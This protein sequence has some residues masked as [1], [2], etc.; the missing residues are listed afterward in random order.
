MAALA[1]NSAT[2]IKKFA[3]CAR[4]WAWEYL[5]GLKPPQGAAA[6]L[7][8]DCH[9]VLERWLAK[10]VSPDLSSR[11]G[12]IV[13][14]GLAHLP[15]PGPHLEVERE[16]VFKLRGHLYRGFVDLGYWNVQ[17]LWVVHDHKTTS[18]FMWALSEEELPHDVQAILYAKEALDRH[19]QDTVLLS[20]LYMRT[21]GK[22]KAEPRYIEVRR[23]EI[24]SGML[25]IE[26]YVEQ[27]Q[28]LRRKHLPIAREHPHQLG[29]KS[30]V[31][32]LEP[33]AHACAAFG[34]CPFIERCNL[35]KR[36]KIRSI[37]A[38]DGK[39]L[40]LKERMANRKASRGDDEPEASKPVAVARSRKPEVNP[41]EGDDEASASLEPAKVEAQERA[42][43]RKPRVVKPVAVAEP[44][45]EEATAEPTAEETRGRGRPKGST[46]KKLE[47]A[48]QAS[49]ETAF[50]RI[51][52]AAVSG[53]EARHLNI[54][55]KVWESYKNEFME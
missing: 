1:K 55:E 15:T 2:Q 3:S 9:A 35:T 18:D 33:N 30:I 34:G 12:N 16:F 4:L 39:K 21:R 29:E 36:E 28:E 25:V 10:G 26:H 50:V 47:E 43:G 51:F 41:P 20:W 27:M 11:E 32:D 40:S 23:D 5:E 14:P 49:H 8:Q 24:E 46:N 7:G 48:S 53:G 52:A 6:T 42:K 17:G 31:L 44:A 19:E 45:A 22:P 13:L 54:A 38:Q 37:M